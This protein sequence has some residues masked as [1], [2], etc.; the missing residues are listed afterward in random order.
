M[1]MKVE[2][3]LLDCP[4]CG[5][6]AELYRRTSDGLGAFD[7]YEVGCFNHKCSVMPQVSADTETIAQSRW[8]KR[9][10]KDAT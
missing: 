2:L 10:G 4:F 6:K 7:Y 8:N 1:I 5:N 3:P 9:N